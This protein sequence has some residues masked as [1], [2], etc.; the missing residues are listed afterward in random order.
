MLPQV[1]DD[2]QQLTGLLAGLHSGLAWQA[3]LFKLKA[4]AAACPCDQVYSRHVIDV[5]K[6]L[7][8]SG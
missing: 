3:Y 6:V 2:M 7:L 4:P 1:L 8:Q 5:T